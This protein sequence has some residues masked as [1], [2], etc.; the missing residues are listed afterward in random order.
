MPLMVIVHH[1]TKEVQENEEDKEM[2]DNLVLKYK[3]EYPN[4][5]K[6]EKIT[7]SKMGKKLLQHKENV[8]NR[9]KDRKGI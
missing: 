8:R 1:K 4:V 9:K 5:M 7:F 2:E 3:K 6:K